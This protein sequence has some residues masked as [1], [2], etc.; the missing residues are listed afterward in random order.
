MHYLVRSF[1]EVLSVERQTKTYSDTRSEFDIIRESS[2][3]S[4]IDLS[5][6][7]ELSLVVQSES[8]WSGSYLGKG[9]GV[10]TIFACHFHTNIVATFRV[11][12][13]SGACLGL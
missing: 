10:D 8:V 12:R 7:R 9:R 1:V 11:P 4:V 3:A 13:G 5:L 2:N 6:R